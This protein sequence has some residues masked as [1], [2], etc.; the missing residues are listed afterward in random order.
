M[1]KGKNSKE[2]EKG[3]IRLEGIDYKEICKTAL[4]L[5]MQLDDIRLKQLE[6]GN[7]IQRLKSENKSLGQQR[8]DIDKQR[9]ELLLSI[10]NY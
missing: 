1:S 2:K 7:T 5:S 8:S 9:H 3:I 6:N 4:K 10:N